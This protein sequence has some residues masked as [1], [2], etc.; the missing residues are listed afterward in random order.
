MS[1]VL[2]LWFRGGSLLA[3]A[4]RRVFHRQPPSAE[5]FRLPVSREGDSLSLWLCD[6]P[7]GETLPEGMSPVPLRA[8]L[9]DSDT[10]Q[11]AQL[12]RAA[13]LHTWHCNHRYCCRCGAPTER[14]KSD[15]AAHCERCNYQQY[16]RIS[17]CI[18]VLIR[19]GE[20]CLLAHAAHYG[21]GRYSTLAGFIEAGE[22]AEE[23]VAREVREEVGVE[24]HN[25]RYAFSQSWP[26]PHA[27]MLGFYADYAGGEIQ[28]DG[29]E[30]LDAQWFDR[31]Q[32]PDLPPPF[33]ISRRLINGFLES[34]IDPAAAP[35]D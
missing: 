31:D 30:I 6:L 29:V 33:T 14:H 16:P 13:Q 25:I 35:P 11:F 7:E 8:L 23:A 21:P 10:A 12:S 26:F 22:T 32:F 20:R 15:L 5:L 19:H 34:A 4:Q 3:D 24:V 27:L 2:Y 18:I 28:P 1:D 9:A 17:P